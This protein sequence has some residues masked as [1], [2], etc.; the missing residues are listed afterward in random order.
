MILIH[1]IILKNDNRIKEKWA[2]FEPKTLFLSNTFDLV[3]THSNII[4]ITIR[5]F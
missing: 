3:Q 5:S 1:N 4:I 2:R